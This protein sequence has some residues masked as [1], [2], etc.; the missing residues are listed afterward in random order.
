MAKIVWDQIG[1][2]FYQAG[3][4]RGVLYVFDTSE[5]DYGSGVAW[6][7]L[8][9]VSENPT[10]AEANPQY[11]DNIKYLNLVSAEEFEAAIEAYTYPNEFA[12]C[13]GSRVVVPG[14]HVGQQTRKMFA[15][16]YRT[17]VGNDLLDLDYGY[18]IHLVYGALASPT[19]K[20]YGTENDSPE[21][22]TFSWDLTT[23]P[24]PIT[25]FKPSA[26][27]I[28]E[29][30]NADEDCLVAL[31]EILYGKDAV[32]EDTQN[33]IPAEDAVLPRIPMPDELLTIMTPAAG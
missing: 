31:E 8:I 33:N 19:D 26:C 32:E 4:D 13:D 18:K 5:L 7:G 28:I 2:R 6:N 22:I 20:S 1:E 17:M 11:A 14:L 27:L 30:Y 10:G 29:S 15:L 3:V 24:V 23:T 21:A 16:T 25:G 9:N 12:E